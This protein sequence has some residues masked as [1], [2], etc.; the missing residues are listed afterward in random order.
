MDQILKHKDSF[1]PRVKHQHIN[2]VKV[3]NSEM[4][5]IPQLLLPTLFKIQFLVAKKCKNFLVGKS[6]KRETFLGIVEKTDSFVI[7]NNFYRK[8]MLT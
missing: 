1:S 6:V 2:K 4:H 8:R 7:L 5:N 3:I